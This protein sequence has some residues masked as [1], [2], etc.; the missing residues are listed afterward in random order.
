MFMK[1]LIIMLVMLIP[2]LGLAQKRG[3]DSA[4]VVAKREFGIMR[5]AY[6]IPFYKRHLATHADDVDALKDLGY[7][8]KIN[9]QYDSAIYYYQQ[10][11][12]LGGIKDNVLAELYAS[13]GL[14]EKAVKAYDSLITGEDMD[15]SNLTYKWYKTR[16]K[17]FYNYGVYYQDTVDYK[18][19]YL[20]MNTPMNEFSPALLDNG[21]VFES[22]RGRKV[23]K[24]NE[25]GWDGKAFTQLYYQASKD[26]LRADQIQNSI[27]LDKKIRKSTSDYTLNSVN[28][29]NIFSAPFDLKHYQYSELLQ[30]PLLDN[31][32]GSKGNYGSISFTKDGKEAYFTKNQ[33]LGAGTNELE[34]WSA[35]RRGGNNWS[36]FKRLPIKEKGSSIFHP[37]ISEDGNRLYFASDQEGGYGGTD[38][39]YAEKEGDGKWGSPINAGEPINTAGN[40]LFPTF[41]EGVLYFSSNGHGGLGGLDVFRYLSNET[42]NEV[43]NVGAPVN[44]EKDD[45]GYSRKGEGGYFSS[46]RYGSD[47]IFEY[48]YKAKHV[49][50]LGKTLVDKVAKE[51]VAMK[52]YSIDKEKVVDSTLTDAQGQYNLKGRPYSRYQLMMDD[53]NGHGMSKDLVTDK[54][55]KDMGTVDIIPEPVI[56]EPDINMQEK[57]NEG[58]VSRRERALLR[59]DDKDIPVGKPRK[60]VVYYDLDKS[61]LTPNDRAVLNE[62]VT[63]M[64]KNKTL[65]A[66]IGSF[67]DCS[68]DMDYNIR[69]SNKR[70]AAVTKYLKDMGVAAGRIVESHYGKN[71]LVKQCEEGNYD[72][73]EQLINRRSEIYLS[74]SKSR[75]WDAINKEDEMY[76][77]LY[78]KDLDN[79]ESLST[80]RNGRQAS[81]RDQ[82][83]SQRNNILPSEEEEEEEKNVAEFNNRKVGLPP[84]PGGQP[85]NNGDT[86]T[87]A[88]YFNVDQYDLSSSFGTLAG[89][90]DLLKSFNDYK[91][92][93]TGH[94]DNEG[95]AA[96]DQKLSERRANTV[97]NYFLSYNI[98]DSRIKVIGY[99]STKPVIEVRRDLYEGWKNRR[100]EIRLFR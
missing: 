22:N 79:P 56:P 76:P 36:K 24:S 20:K 40:E 5:Y 91:C 89:L 69:L 23:S 62:L 29:N 70:S 73:A 32:F 65:N 38:I 58:I 53:G 14:Y 59:D 1:Q 26:N 49:K 8:Y 46:N 88:V 43:E 51:G 87:F 48:E 7:C 31:S 63:E 41:Y 27:W 15:T 66:V 39:Y 42:T 35:K 6:A 30:V 98:P 83:L 93:L 3:S 54:G 19:Y 44:S 67:T 77:V 33:K 47:D 94:T 50:I 78:S 13:M 95:N 37:A 96:Y 17:G 82:P 57:E 34:I 81:S 60:F 2:L 55:D 61:F 99:G 84:I 86:I 11:F 75:K 4:I 28:D 52:L 10:A 85:V 45:L 90:K 74:E 100:V 97:K 92:V 18:L 80:S 25:F 21:F 9:N 71:Y 72:V 16:Q 64:K 12:S 68:A